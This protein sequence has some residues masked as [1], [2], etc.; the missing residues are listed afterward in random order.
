MDTCGVGRVARTAAEVGPDLQRSLVRCTIPVMWE[1]AVSDATWA[2]FGAVAAALIAVGAAQVRLERQLKS[3]TE[4]FDRQLQSQAEQFERSLKSE[5]D[6]HA[7]QLAHNRVV[8]ELEELRRIL[9]DGLTAAKSKRDHFVNVAVTSDE[10]LKAGDV[11]FRWTVDDLYAIRNRLL[12]RLGPHEVVKAFGDATEALRSQGRAMTEHLMARGKSL[13]G[14]DAAEA[15]PLGRVSPGSLAPVE[16][17]DAEQGD[18]QSQPA[19][20]DTAWEAFEKADKASDAA[21]REYL[22]QAREV[23]RVKIAEVERH[24]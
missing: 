12:L 19:S 24:P 16:G 7:Q 2:F 6:R 23:V 22:T 3:Q 17:R 8:N 18:P 21:V 20:I 1:M 10:H 11:D 5:G 15:L 14:Q 13:L 4:Q 9:D